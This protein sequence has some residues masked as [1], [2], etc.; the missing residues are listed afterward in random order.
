M[1]ESRTPALRPIASWG[2][3]LVVLAIG[4]M[5]INSRSQARPISPQAGD[6]RVVYVAT[7]APSQ[8]S[9]IRP[10]E[11]LPQI[12]RQ[13]W[14]SNV[15]GQEFSRRVQAAA[16]RLAA[17]GYAIV[18]VTPLLRGEAKTQERQGGATDV[19]VGGLPTIIGGFGTGWGAGYSVTDG[20]MI[21]GQM[22]PG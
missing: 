13:E 2:L 18:S 10:G 21:V 17:E 4:G 16:A 1:L 9:Q 20:V 19:G 12:Q 3:A 22:P 5:M 15:D 14:S 7:P 11:A 8:A 6:V